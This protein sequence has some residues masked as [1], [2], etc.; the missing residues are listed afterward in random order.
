MIWHFARGVFHAQELLSSSVVGAKSRFP[1]L[2]RA[3]FQV[4]E[5]SDFV[6]VTVRWRVRGQTLESIRKRWIVK[7]ECFD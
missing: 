5:I 3:R 1:G 4:M 6:C 2:D 7:Q